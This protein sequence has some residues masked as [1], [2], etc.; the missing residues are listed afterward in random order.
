MPKKG[1]DG[2]WSSVESEKEERT[3]VRERDQVKEGEAGGG[4]WRKRE[5]GR[6]R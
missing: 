6:E 3:R 2:L 4:S 1:V 5:K